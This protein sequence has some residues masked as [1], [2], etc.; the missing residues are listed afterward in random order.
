[1][2]EMLREL[3]GFQPTAEQLR[4]HFKS[5][6][7]ECAFE[8]GMWPGGYSGHVQKKGGVQFHCTVAKKF[9]KFATRFADCEW[10]FVLVKEIKAGA[11]K[12]RFVKNYGQAGSH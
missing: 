6:T 1:M 7:L 12:Y 4:E 9:P 5:N 2:N 3:G 8:A 10:E 11:D